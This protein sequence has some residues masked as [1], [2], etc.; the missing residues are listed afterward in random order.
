MVGSA[1]ELRYEPADLVFVPFADARDYTVWTQRP[2][3]LRH[4]VPAASAYARATLSTALWL[5]PQAAQRPDTDLPEALTDE[6]PLSYCTIDPRD[7]G[8]WE[9]NGGAPGERGG[10][11]WFTIVLDAP[12]R[13][14]RVVFRHGPL[15]PDGGWFDTA[16]GPPRIEVVRVPMPSWRDTPYPS[17][18]KAPWEA[19]ATLADYPPSDA[20]RP[21]DLAAGAPLTATLAAGAP[22]YAIRVLGRCGG[23]QVSCAELSAYEA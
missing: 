22:I 18:H 11:V 4:D 5:A 10:P 20:N 7:P 1:D 9:I 14:T 19:A 6:N 3:A 15:G 13:I 12:R 8:P 2:D 16:H 17:A 23:S 21:P